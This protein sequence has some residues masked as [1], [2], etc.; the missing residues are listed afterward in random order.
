MARDEQPY[1]LGT[2]SVLP[3]SNNRNSKPNVSQ[4]SVVSG[5]WSVANEEILREEESENCSL[6]R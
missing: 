5:Q 6:T 4:L 1:G 2:L 3:Q